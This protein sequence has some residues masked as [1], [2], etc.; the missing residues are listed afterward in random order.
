MIKRN[1]W[2]L[3]YTKSGILSGHPDLTVRPLSGFVSGFE[4]PVDDREVGEQVDLI[5]TQ[6][7]T[8][9]QEVPEPSRRCRLP[10]RVEKQSF[11]WVSCCYLSCPV[12]LCLAAST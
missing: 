5:L 4:G 2:H 7:M 8:G 3:V 10:T 12:K 11:S 1:T 6:G 9:S